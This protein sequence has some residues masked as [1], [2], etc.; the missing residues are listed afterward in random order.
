MA[1]TFVQK[2]APLEALFNFSVFLIVVAVIA[3]ALMVGLAIFEEI[4]FH[5]SFYGV[6]LFGAGV[7]GCWA[8]SEKIEKVRRTY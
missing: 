4:P 2:V 3:V 1:K 7:L 5:V 6:A 8:T